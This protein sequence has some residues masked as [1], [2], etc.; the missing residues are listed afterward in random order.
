M[1]RI[2]RSLALAALLLLGGGSA[3]AAE[4]VIQVRSAHDV[5]QTADRL[6]RIL[7]Q[8]GMRIFARIDHAAGAATVGRRLPP[9][10][11]LIFGNPKV[12]TP[13]MQCAPSVAI[14]LPQKALI[15]QDAAGRVWLAYND[16]DYLRERHGIRGCDKVLAKVKRALAS[17]ARAATAP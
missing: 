7:R 3:L 5:H 2:P 15:R 14:D 1:N 12:G 16:P 4:G 17:F 8:K 13:L 11:L 9:T 6:E 10:E